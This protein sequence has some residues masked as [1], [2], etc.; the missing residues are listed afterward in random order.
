MGGTVWPLKMVSGTLSSHS[1]SVL[2]LFAVEATGLSTASVEA[3]VASD[4]SEYN[5]DRIATVGC[6]L[7][8]AA[9]DVRLTARYVYIRTYDHTDVKE[10]ET[11]K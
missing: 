1:S 11:L 5:M 2:A 3:I 7:G 9:V 6:C 8:A 10:K 4:K